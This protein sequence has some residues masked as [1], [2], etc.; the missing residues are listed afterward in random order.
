M[1]IDPE[2]LAVLTEQLEQ[3]R[4]QFEGGSAAFKENRDDYL[5]AIHRELPPRVPSTLLEYGNHFQVQSSIL[6]WDMDE[7]ISAR[8]L[9]APKSDA[10]SY[11]NND[12]AKR[13]VE[14]INIWNA[15]WML[16]DDEGGKSRSAVFANM[17]SM[18]VAV[19]RDLQR[20]PAKTEAEG[21]DKRE[22]EIRKHES[23]FKETHIDPRTMRWGPD[24][25]DPD[26]IFEEAVVTV[27]QARSL[28]DSTGRFPSIDSA[29]KVL[30]IGPGE[31]VHT[32][33]ERGTTPRHRQ[34]KFVRRN[35]RVPESGYR[36]WEAGTW[37]ATEFVCGME[38]KTTDYEELTEYAIDS[39][40]PEYYIIPAG[41][42]KHNEVNPH[43]HYPP[44]G[45]PLITAVSEANFLWTILV[46][47]GLGTL[48]ME[49]VYA[50]LAGVDK[51]VANNYIGQLRQLSVP[52]VLEGQPAQ[53]DGVI[54]TPTKEGIGEVPLL[55]PLQQWP[56]PILDQFFQ[57]L[58]SL[59]LEIQTYRTN[60]FLT[61]S[62]QQEAAQGSAT[63]LLAQM[64]A[65]GIGPSLDTTKYD[66]YREA[67]FW[68][69]R[70]AILT[71]S[72]GDEGSQEYPL[73][74]SSQEPVRRGKVD[75]G[76]EIVIDAEKMRRHFTLNVTTDSH[77]QQE[78]VIENEQAYNDF[79]RGID[80]LPVLLERLGIDD[81]QARMDEI[82]AENERIA[83]EQQFAS[84]REAERA[85]LWG[86]LT[87]LNIG[88]LAE[89]A[90]PTPGEEQ[91]AQGAPQGNGV[92]NVPGNG[93]PGGGAPFMSPP[94]IDFG[95]DVRGDL[96]I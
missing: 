15:S 14:E 70:E 89:S 2:A 56:Q 5:A 48:T 49:S 45:K 62:A 46:L 27:Y 13:D 96:V 29:G 81:P 1:P 92:G 23:T 79:D 59:D 84:V 4:D 20:P 58:A 77:T 64:Q 80:P 30:F 94:A 86:S 72:D 16:R 40:R 52:Q 31:N 34:L 95:G 36:E 82:D 7:F 19:T 18:G 11:E 66:S 38:G 67:L 74:T 39:K 8:M 71:W 32:A 65:A 10:T 68:G 37:V 50:T 42:V 76:K 9:G 90:Q 88:A 78:Q 24:L 12:D 43:Y 60:R 83:A 57:R 47:A 28:R 93:L 69:R 87:E 17:Y 53:R 25:D 85:V 3:M 63:G 6:A 55:P 35:M 21:R 75:P 41:S 22:E 44:R 91:M 26:L 33:D 54:P 51:D 61:G 73:V